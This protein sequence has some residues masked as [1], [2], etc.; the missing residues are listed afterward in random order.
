[1]D[2]S[3]REFWEERYAGGGSEWYFSLEVL[4]P[5]LE[6]AAGLTRISDVLEIGCGDRPLVTV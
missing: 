6:R 1:M 4:R 3:R 2:Y 5:V